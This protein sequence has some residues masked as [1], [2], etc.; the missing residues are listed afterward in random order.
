M[1]QDAVDVERSLHLFYVDLA[2][3][4]GVAYVVEKREVEFAVLAFLVVAHKFDELWIV[5]ARDVECTIVAAHVVGK[6]IEFG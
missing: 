6:T 1:H 2:A 3:R 4:L 5:V